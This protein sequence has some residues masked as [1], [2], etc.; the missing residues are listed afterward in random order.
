[1]SL[2][3]YQVDNKS[4]LLDFKSLS[5]TI[6]EASRSSGSGNASSGAAGSGAP[7]SLN[8][9]LSDSM[10]RMVFHDSFNSEGGLKKRTSGM[11]Y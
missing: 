5:P 1:M 3:L 2:Q 4:Y 7:T 8:S 11:I 10:G 6:D 9:S